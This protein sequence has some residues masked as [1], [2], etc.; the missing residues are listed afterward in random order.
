MKSLRGLHLQLDPVSGIAGD[1]TVAALVDAGVPPAVVTD[2]IA[3]IGLPGLRVR[4][5]SRRQGAFVGRAFVV[6]EPAVGRRPIAP[7]PKKV[8]RDARGRG[9]GGTE[10]HEHHPG[11]DHQD[12]HRHADDDRAKRH[13]QARSKSRGD[14]ADHHHRDYSEI[15]GLLARAKFDAAAKALAHEI[16]A[17]LAEVEAA[18]HGSSVEHVT[19]HE[20]GAFDSIADI[21][22]MSAAVAWLAPVSIGSSAPVLGTGTVHTAHGIVPVPA[23]ATAELLRGI[24]VIA[25]GPG[26]LTT[27]TGAVFL[28]TVVDSFG[29]PPPMRIHAVGYG[30]GTRVLPDRANVLRV[31]L[32]EPI[33][34]SLPP[35]ATDVMVLETNVDDMAG[36]LVAALFDALF[37]AGALDVWASPILMKKGRPAQLVSA[38]VEP[39]RAS[40][41]QRAFFL[42]STTLGVR[43]FPMARITLARSLQDVRT[44]WGQV[45]IK[46]GAV[47]GE[48][49][50][51]E[52]EFEDCRRLASAARIPVR[53]VWA[54]AVAAAA[55]AG[56]NSVPHAPPVVRKRGARGVAPRTRT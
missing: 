26:E 45:A 46:I 44:P 2:A 15:R 54:A 3:S 47:D 32:G 8:P 55:A 52:P 16:F 36:N 37:A 9:A 56:L 31:M 38:L 39:E 40:I 6:K 20:V 41:V 18:L 42:N 28:A 43:M 24:P 25:E 13:A 51:A 53:R 22:G 34:R 29:P 49:I 7:G 27:P 23:P 12:G 17:R 10:D 14:H 5:E 19:F 21:V 50:G 4:F 30:A 48:P 1:M 35:A 33:G 11:H